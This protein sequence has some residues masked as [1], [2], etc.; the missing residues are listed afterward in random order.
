M[1]AEQFDVNLASTPVPINIIFLD[2]DGVLNSTLVS[3]SSDR[4]LDLQCF[5]RLL[6]LIAK[7]NA[8]V[9]LSPSWRLLPKLKAELGAHFI[10][11]GLDL[12]LL[13]GQTPERRD[14]PRAAEIAEWVGEHQEQVASWVVLDDIYMDPEITPA[15]AGTVL[16]C[17][18]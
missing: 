17:T 1:T 9:V 2:I 3:S 10:H 5:E 7:T 6:M 14:G 11:G 13:V 12:A 4:G 18:L 16:C 8:R 15:I